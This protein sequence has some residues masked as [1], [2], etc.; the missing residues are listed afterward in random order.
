MR[1]TEV[2]KSSQ[3]ATD[4]LR[5]A[6][7]EGGGFYNRHSAMQAAGIAML[8]PYW[9]RLIREVEIGYG[10]LVIADYGS[11]QGRNSMIPIRVAIEDLRA[12]AHA[13]MPIEVIH[14]DLP[15]NDYTA[16]FTALEEDPNSYMRATTDVFPSAVG[17]SYFDPIIAPKRVHLG[18]N[19]WTVQWLS[20]STVNAP[21][22]VF[23]A[24]TKSAEVR[25]ALR[26]LQASDWRRFLSARSTELCPGGRLL[27][28]FPALKPEGSGWEWLGGEL[29]GAITDLGHEGILS[30]AEQLLL[31]I[32]TAPRMVEDIREPFLSDGCFA[33]LEIQDLDV[34]QVADPVWAAF[35]I[36]G[37]ARALASGHANMMRAFSGPTVAGILAG[38]SDQRIVV[39][40]IYD[41]LAGRVAAAP[42]PHQPN[43]AVVTLRKRH[44]R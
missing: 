26:S 32:P 8:L 27:T 16:L 25:A 38:R 40:Q 31:T 7:M 5:G 18:W 28:A 30:E 33:G 13:Q 19:T 36:S 22:H 2:T 9:E 11:S 20:S 15:S 17:R 21:D 4:G 43:L 10:P 39:D 14:T 37:D 3:P 35:Q 34:V 44:E 12:R 29:W 23:T 24:M 41:R 42:R 6:A 1:E